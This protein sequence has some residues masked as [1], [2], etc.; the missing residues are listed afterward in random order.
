M[1]RYLLGFI[2]ALILIVIVVGLIFTGF[3]KSNINF[4]HEVNKFA[5]YS[6]TS[7]VT[8]LDINGPIIASQSHNEVI[9]SVSNLDVNLQVLQGYDGK[10]INNQMFSNSQNSYNAFLRS[11]IIAG[12]N[13][14][15]PSASS[16]TNP[17]GLCSNGNTYTFKMNLGQK[18][19][20]NSWQTNCYNAPHTFNGDL[21]ATVNLF[22]AQ[23]P[24]YSSYVSNLNL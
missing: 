14:S 22:I 24:N 19:I 5:N 13:S 12:F 1:T 11:L 15:N 2:V 8:S 16:L 6:T 23:V 9:I 7:A 3:N 10:V 4:G 20:V 21:N 17:V 18:N